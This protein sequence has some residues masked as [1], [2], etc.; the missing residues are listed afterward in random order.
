M[1]KNIFVKILTVA[2]IFSTLLSL[3]ASCMT[4]ESQGKPS[5]TYNEKNEDTENK[6]NTPDT[7]NKPSVEEDP[8]IKITELMVVNT[9]GAEDIEGKTS[10]WIELLNVS[11]REVDLSE[12]LIRT[13]ESELVPL[14]KITVAPG[15]YAIVFANGKIGDDSVE[16]KLSSKSII[17]LMHGELFCSSLLYV[18][19]TANHS[20]VAE[21]GSETA[22]PTPGYENVK[23]KDSLV[24]SELMSSNSLYPIDGNTCD[25]IELYNASDSPIDL[26]KQ[27]IST[28]S[29]EPYR[30]KLPDVILEAGEYFLLACERDLPFKLSKDGES[31]YITRNDGVL[32]ASLTY[33]AMEKNTSLTCDNGAVDYPTPGRANTPDE[34]I[35]MICERKGL[36]ISEVISSNTKYA[37][38]NKKYYC[39]V[40]EIFNNSDGD[41]LLSDYFFS[42]KGSDLQKYRLPEVTLK[43]GEYYLIYC[44]DEVSGAAPISISSSGEE[45]WLSRADGYVSDALSLPAIP[46]NRSYGRSEG[47]LVYFTTPSL[48]KANVG[49]YE[50]ITKTPFASIPSG[51]YSESVSV[52][53]SGEGDIYYTTDGSEPT[54]ESTLYSGEAITLESSG[55]IRAIA[56]DGDRIPSEMVTM[57]YII[58]A[59]THDLPVVYLSATDDDIFGES[60]IYTKYSSSKEV[61][62]NVTMFENGKEAFSVNC[63]LKIFGGGSRELPKKSFQLKFRAKYGVSRLEYDLFDSEVRDFNSLV[64]RCGEDYNRAIFR[65]ELQTWIA[66][67]AGMEILTQDYRFCTLYINGKY[68]GIYCFKERIDEHFISSH[69]SDPVS[70][71]TLLSG[72]GKAEHGTLAEYN[73]LVKYIKNHDLSNTE[74]YEYVKERINL[75]SIIDWMVIQMYVGNQD[76]GNIRYYK[77]SDGKWNWILYDLDW[78]FNAYT[79][80]YNNYYHTGV[81]LFLK[82]SQKGENFNT[83]M[84]G[85]LKNEEFVDLF[86][87]RFAYHMKETFDEEKI[88]AKIDEIASVIDSEV[89]RERKRWGSSYNS[90][91]TSVNELRRFVTDLGKGSRARA[92]IQQLIDR[93]SLDDEAIIKYFGEEY[94]GGYVKS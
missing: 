82:S 23:E 80:F 69:T 44:D 92:L 17:T 93:F 12:Y 88:L 91:K 63:G 20:F 78:G 14:P 46:L 67:Q 9:V 47:K 90:W 24:I 34:H 68:W 73:A 65:D 64:L 41:I 74:Y 16:L 89:Q 2:L 37:L 56:Y 81:S 13:T 35:A 48:G 22:F 15:E 54:T 1:L 77:G 19:K 66:D 70:D 58:I 8:A 50:A 21:N 60:G 42:D 26:S 5:D 40:V 10:P 36:V 87:S 85:L 3:L 72:Y 61:K 11:D 57:P 94:L 79:W 75:N 45:I 59:H 43:P 84:N 38:F 51:I 27:Y 86:Y 28:E 83:I 53:L 49:G 30:V 32:T 76:L 29:T 6:P 4:N 55:A 18:N 7:D 25:W 62:A 39:D 31:I 33:E 71:I 52:T